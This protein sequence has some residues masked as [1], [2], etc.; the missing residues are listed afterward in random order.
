MGITRDKRRKGGFGACRPVEELREWKLEQA[1]NRFSEVVRL[2]A[3]EGPQL[4]TVNGREAAIIVAPR[5]YRE[6]LPMPEDQAPLA[7]FLAGLGLGERSV[8]RGGGG[9]RELEL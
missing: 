8:H 7:E 3:A 9:D 1:R 2:A 5:D 4:V 6:L